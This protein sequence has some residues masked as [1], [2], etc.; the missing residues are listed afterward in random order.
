[1][2]RYMGQVAVF[3]ALVPLGKPITN[4]PDFPAN[5]YIDTL[6]LARWKKLGIIPSELCTDSEFVRRVHLD[7]CGRL[8]TPHEVRAFLADTQA[9]RRTRLIQPLLDSP[10]YPP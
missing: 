2:A 6:A 4:Y 10:A 9:D 7:L 5:N 8:P 3:R 1:M